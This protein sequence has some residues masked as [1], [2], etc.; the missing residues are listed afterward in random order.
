M[1]TEKQTEV[2]DRE[3]AMD[4]LRS[5]SQAATHK[6]QMLN[7]KEQSNRRKFSKGINM[8][9][10]LNAL[11]HAHKFIIPTSF[12]QIIFLNA[13]TNKLF[14]SMPKKPTSIPSQ[15]FSS[16]A[17]AITGTPS[18]SFTQPRTDRSNVTNI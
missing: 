6:H 8:S 18:L 13:L 15:K 7:E 5:A 9:A 17:I 16:L 10:Y 12:S 1:L 3:T 14:I 2:N 4:R 11:S